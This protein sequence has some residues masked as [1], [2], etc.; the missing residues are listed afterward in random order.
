MFLKF[1]PRRVNINIIIPEGRAK[2]FSKKLA[3]DKDHTYYRD[4]LL[5]ILKKKFGECETKCK[6]KCAADLS[7]RLHRLRE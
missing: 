2:D 3:L 6:N 4:Y 7:E 5:S 1:E